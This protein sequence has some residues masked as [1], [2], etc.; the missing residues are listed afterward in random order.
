[1][2]INSS[3]QQIAGGVAT[4]VGGLIISKDISG[5]LLH[6][7][8]V[9]YIAVAIMVLTIYLMW[10]IHKMVKEP[11]IHYSDEKPTSEVSETP[12]NEIIS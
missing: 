3:I 8:T 9:G 7:D 6:F 10:F 12:A 1:M 11:G 5:K 2:G 4:M